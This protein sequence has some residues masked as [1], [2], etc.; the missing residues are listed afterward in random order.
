MKLTNS[1][2][3][4]KKFYNSDDTKSIELTDIL[5]TINEDFLKAIEDGE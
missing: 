1:E 2:F 3:I 4:M 5:V